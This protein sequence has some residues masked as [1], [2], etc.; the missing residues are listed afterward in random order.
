MKTELIKIHERNFNTSPSLFFFSPGRVNLIGEHTDYSGG[1]VLPISISLGIYAAVSLRED[2]GIYVYSDDFRSLGVI[3]T[4]EP[5]RYNQSQGY[6]NY[7]EGILSVLK[8]DGYCIG[9]GLN[10]SLLSTLPKSAG[11]SSSAALEVLIL[12]LLNDLNDLKLSKKQIVTYAKE[13][14][15]TYIGVSSGVM[16]QFIITFGQENQA[17]LLDTETLDYNL[18]PF[19]F[20]NYQLVLMNTNKARDLVDSAYN[21]RFN[22]IEKAK[23][24]FDKPLGKVSLPLYK[25]NVHQFNDLLQKRVLHVVTE[26]ARTKAAYEALK[27]HD[28]DLLGR[29]MVESHRSLR[30]DFEVSC[31]ELDY[32]V[33]K[34]LSYGAAGA[35]M[36]GAG[37]GGTMVALYSNETLL[38][39]D[40][41]K[42]AYKAKFDLELDIYIAQGAAGA[43]S[44]EGEF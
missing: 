35:R 30:D 2:K 43:K 27:V 18:I 41:L 3:Q 37:F 16:D 39:F 7:I 12:T 23:Q 26:N 10:I 44:I 20:E 29:L 22:S 42:K 24:Y 5:Y 13:V 34:N 6:M 4:K 1:Y 31:K 19:D 14:E 38:N 33:D 32:L 21:E 40:A 8:R 28:Y 9:K 11:L 15:N 36:T 25:A 17:L